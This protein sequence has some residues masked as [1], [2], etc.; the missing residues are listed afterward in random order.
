MKP[1]ILPVAL[2]VAVL[3]ASLRAAAPAA[4]VPPLEVPG[5]APHLAL[6]AEDAGFFPYRRCS[7]SNECVA[8]IN[9]WCTTV[10]VEGVVVCIEEY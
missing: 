9:T 7:T 6:V 2:A 10:V 3:S 5:P 4:G 1:T 8:S